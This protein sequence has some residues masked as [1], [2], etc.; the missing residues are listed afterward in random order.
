MRRGP[1]S[2]PIAISELQRPPLFSFT[3][4]RRAIVPASMTSGP[5]VMP[6]HAFHT[7]SM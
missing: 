3:P 6:Q 2:L 4:A 5:I 1:E 7:P